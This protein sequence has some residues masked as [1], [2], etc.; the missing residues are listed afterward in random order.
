MVEVFHF[1]N[2]ILAQGKK[3]SPETV[4]NLHNTPDFS[5]LQQTTETYTFLGIDSS[6]SFKKSDFL[7]T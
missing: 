3:G 7:A 2:S 4:H 1:G 5:Q 6:W